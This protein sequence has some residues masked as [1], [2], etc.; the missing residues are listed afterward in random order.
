MAG[1]ATFRGYFKMK[2]RSLSLIASGSLLAV[3]S[4]SSSAVVLTAPASGISFYAAAAGVLPTLGSGASDVSFVSGGAIPIVGAN[5]TP[6]PSTFVG[7]LAYVVV[8]ENSTGYLDFLCQYTS[9]SGIDPVWSLSLTDFAGFTDAYYVHT[10]T[11]EKDPGAFAKSDDNT[12]AFDFSGFGIPDHSISGSDKSAVLIVNTH[13]FKTM[14]GSTQLIDGGIVTVQT[15]APAPV[16]EPTS[17]AVLGLGLLG[18]VARR[19]K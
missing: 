2:I 19:R 17:Y 14:N 15:P 13:S 7:T 6:N 3:L 18:L 16:P 4:A 10:A 12:I 9:I 8:S 11:G 5:A 1:L